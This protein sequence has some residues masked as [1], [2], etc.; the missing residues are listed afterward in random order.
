MITFMSERNST[1]CS[2]FPFTTAG[3]DIRP[4]TA[5]LQAW[6][7]CVNNTTPSLAL[8]LMMQSKSNISIEVIKNPVEFI[9]SLLEKISMS[10]NSE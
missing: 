10:D 1:R 2:P 3:R 7:L 9:E 4:P 5:Y 6:I 8:D